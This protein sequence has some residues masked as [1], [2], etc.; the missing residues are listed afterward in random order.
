MNLLETLAKEY[1]IPFVGGEHKVWF[2]RTRAGQFYHDFKLNKFIALGWICFHLN[3]LL[4][5]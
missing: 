2:F 3:L 1:N 4:K 5:Q